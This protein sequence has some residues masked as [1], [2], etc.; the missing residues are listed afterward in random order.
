[1]VQSASRSP[2]KWAA[3]GRRR[4][5]VGQAQGGLEWHRPAQLGVCSG[6]G[7]GLLWGQ[8]AQQPLVP[9]KDL[10]AA[11]VSGIKLNTDRGGFGCE[12][13]G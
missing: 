6:D 7:V 8:R 2:A 9:G 11:L 12:D 5:E 3:V 4:P 10:L 1:M 13:R